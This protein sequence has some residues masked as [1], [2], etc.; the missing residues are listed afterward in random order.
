MALGQKLREKLAAKTPCVGSWVSFTDPTITEILGEAGYDFL[1]IDGEHASLGIEA[2]QLHLI[3]ASAQNV[4][5]IVRVLGNEP[6]YIKQVL[7]VGAPAVM[8]PW[9]RTV[10]DARQAISFCFYPPEGMRGFGP[11]RAA[12]YGR[13][14]KD[15]IE[16]ANQE[17]M[18]IIQIEHYQAVENL[19][20]IIKIPGIGALFIGPWDLSGS[21]GLLGEVNHPRVKEA[22]D[23][24]ISQAHS[25]EV[26]V[27]IAASP[28]PE[29][30][31][32]WFSQGVQFVTMGN[33]YEILAQSCDKSVAK[34]R[35]LLTEE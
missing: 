16:R 11:R 19:D 18:V 8:I 4:V 28:L 35:N 17:L 32:K 6:T 1:V 3:A 31:A 9:V 29:E 13:R 15:Y 24:V 33:D 23:V 14:G 7:D 25:A 21:L 10:D 27:G 20:Q 5:P 34:F 22:I 2:I 30:A 26:P 12:R